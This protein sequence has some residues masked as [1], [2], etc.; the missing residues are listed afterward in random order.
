MKAYYS[1]FKIRLLKGLQY[2]VA[3]YAGVLTQ[4]FWGFMYI[5]IF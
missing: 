5:M 2:K 3:A 1:L 4:F